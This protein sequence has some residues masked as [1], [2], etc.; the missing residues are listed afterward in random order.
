MKKL[1]VGF[2]GCGSITY[3]HLRNLQKI[4]GVDI[5]GIFDPQKEN[6]ERFRKESGDPVVYDSDWALVEKGNLDAVVISSPHT[7]HFSQIKLALENGLHVLVEKPAVVSYQEAIEVR[8]L[9]QK[10]RKVF[11]V[12][13]QRH[14]QSNFLAARKILEEKKI[15]KILF[16]SGF[17]AQNWIELIKR[18]GRLWRFDPKLSGGGQL[19]DSGSHFV[20][21]LFWLTG[22]TPL[23]VSSFIDYRGMKIDV[24][25][26]FIVK[27]KEGCLANFGILGID[28]GFRE[29]MFI[30]GEK[31]MVK[32]SAS[33]E[34]S[35]V[36]YNGQAEPSDLT[37]VSSPVKS[38]A[39]DLIRCIQTGTK[40]ATDFSVIEKVALLSDKIYQA[41]R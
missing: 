38:P 39:E 34:N 36:H 6:A 27:F 21:L 11:V 28:P 5:A 3:G 23:T 16:V 35:Y 40:P 29:A 17:L 15:G 25:T 26:A 18:S 14:Y 31:G 1:K 32:V 7:F 41:S 24:N 8:K 13:Y 10:T 20:A 22:L 33:A 19:T 9:L 37:P 4:K 12:G 2:I 30:W